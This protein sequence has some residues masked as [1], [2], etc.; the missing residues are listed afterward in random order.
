M[1]Q[2]EY[3]PSELLCPRSLCWVPA[4]RVLA[5]IDAADCGYVVLSDVPGALV[6]LGQEQVTPRNL[7]TNGLSR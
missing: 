5:A 2:A 6:N 1:L 7:M 3:H 4:E